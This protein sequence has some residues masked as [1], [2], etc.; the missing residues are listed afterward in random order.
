LLK[1]RIEQNIERSQSGIG[2][3]LAE[4][5]YFGI[6]KTNNPFSGYFLNLL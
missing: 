2:K 3:N 1:N 4:N 5:P 6:N